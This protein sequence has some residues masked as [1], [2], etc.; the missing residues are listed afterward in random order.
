MCVCVCGCVCWD[1]FSPG[2]TLIALRG[3]NT[4]GWIEEGGEEPAQSLKFLSDPP[5]PQ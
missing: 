4:P 3:K 1:F 5:L 2:V